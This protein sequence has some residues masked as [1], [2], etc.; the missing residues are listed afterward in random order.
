MHLPITKDHLTLK[1][2]T[3]ELE[4]SGLTSE[5]WLGAKAA[6]N[7]KV[8]SL[9]QYLGIAI[10]CYL[11]F[12]VLRSKGLAPNY[13]HLKYPSSRL[14][15]ICAL[16]ASTLSFAGTSVQNNS[17]WTS[18]ESF[19]SAGW[20]SETLCWWGRGLTG[21]SGINRG[22]MGEAF[23]K[24]FLKNMRKRI[25]EK[26]AQGIFGD[27]VCFLSLDSWCFQANG[28]GHTEN[29]SWVDGTDLS[30]TSQLWGDGEPSG[31]GK[32]VYV[33]KKS[34][35][36]KYRTLDDALCYDA[37][38]LIVCSCQTGKMI[39]LCTKEPPFNG[40]KYF[41]ARYLMLGASYL[42][43]AF[44][45]ATVPFRS[46]FALSLLTPRSLKKLSFINSFWFWTN[47]RNKL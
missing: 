3:D 35:D 15:K 20:S 6:A 23:R 27:F 42:G 9:K 1:Y 30:L 33:Q 24:L 43:L 28:I 32:C 26:F 25:L 14:L 5:F 34:K 17:F 21:T 40:A 39:K 38:R 22:L 41:Q 19:A 46:I 13:M 4:T 18:K 37:K 2:L 31:D 16:K 12:C 44:L 29:F 8:V 36:I 11:G 7:F 47:L 10:L 45:Y